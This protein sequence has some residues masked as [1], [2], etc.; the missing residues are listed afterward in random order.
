MS[1]LWLP[2]DCKIHHHHHHKETSKDSRPVGR[3]ICLLEARGEGVPGIAEGSLE[4][5]G[6][7]SRSGWV[8]QARPWICQSEEWEPGPG[9]GLA[10]S[11]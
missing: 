1:H 3:S 7:A 5:V 6:W 2:T 4:P 10:T 9:R 11:P 8:G